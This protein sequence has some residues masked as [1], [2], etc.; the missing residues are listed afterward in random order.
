MVFF[1]VQKLLS[2]IKSHLFIFISIIL[3]GGSK[4]IFAVIIVKEC[5]S[6]AFL[7][8]FYRVQSYI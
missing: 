1:A 3:G 4:K 6:Y 5:S 8:E 2:F 7:Q